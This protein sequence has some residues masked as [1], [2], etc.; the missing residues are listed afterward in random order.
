MAEIKLHVVHPDVIDV[1]FL[2]GMLNRMDMS[3]F[4]YKHPKITVA[5]G[6]NYIESVKQRLRLYE[7]GGDY[8]GTHV[9]AGNL[10][11]LMDCSNFFMC[12]FMVMGGITSPNFQPQDSNTSPGLVTDG[13]KPLHQVS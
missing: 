3:Y 2:Q 8:H 6:V 9:E 10:E 1:D 4:K 12:E 7:K 5:Q 13:D 11:W